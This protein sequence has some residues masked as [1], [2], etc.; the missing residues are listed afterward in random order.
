[1]LPRSQQRERYELERSPL[2]QK[3]TQRDV[4]QLLGETRDDLRRLRNYKEHFI[5]RR[6]AI[7]GKKGK[8]RELAYPEGRLRALHERLKYQLNKV[9]Q[10]NYLFS[11]RLRRSQRDN[12]ALHLEQNQY[13]TLDLKQFYPS[14]N[15]SMVRSWMRD[16]LGMY[17][18]VSG[19]LTDLCTVDGKVSFGSPLT[20]VLCSL[21]H[22][23]MF[24]QIARICDNRGLTYSVWVDDL[25]ISGRFIPGEVLNEIRWVVRDAGLK[26]HAVK[27][28]N[29]NRPVFIT[30]I[31]VVGRKLI[32]PSSLNLKIRV[33][34]SEYHT[35]LSDD[36]RDEICQRLLSYL[37][38]LRHISGSTSETG[39]KIS[40]QMNSLR[41]KRS[42]RRFASEATRNEVTKSPPAP[43]MADPLGLPW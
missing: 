26:S 34:W 3:P 9:K 25:T 30:G 36:E 24:D 20:P 16:Q 6:T 15:E 1:M 17:E 4:A 31:G 33:A 41:Q 38:T 29:G 8:I 10:P 35:A 13:L 40:D 32:A 19:L 14:T 22:K 42:A 39:R 2:A 28:R 7:I 43:K 23:S 5:V 18:D 11:P 27:Y 37:G 21:I 12:A